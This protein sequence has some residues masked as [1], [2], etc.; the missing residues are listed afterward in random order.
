M[1]DLEAFNRGAERKGTSCIKW[2]FQ[3]ADYGMENL[4]PFSIADADYPTY[5]PILE[6]LKRRIDNGVIGYTDLGEDYFSAV[7]GWCRRRHGWE[8]EHSWVV[9][10]GGI[11]P[12]MCNAIEALLPPDGKVIVQPPVYDPFYSIIEASGR[13][14]VKNDLICDENGYRMDYDG[15]EKACKDGA[16]MLLLCSP[17]NP[18]CRVWTEEELKQVADICGRYGVYVVSDE[19]HWD[20]IMDGYHHTT[21]GQFHELYERL[22]VCTSCSKTFNIAGLETSNL[23]IPGKETRETYQK[24]LYSRYLFCPNTLGLEAVKAAYADGDQWVDSQ[25]AYLTGNAKLVCDFMAEH[26][27]R[28]RVARPEGTYLL[29]LDMTDYG[30]SSDELIRRIAQAGAG[31]NGGNHYGEAYDGFVRMN[32][33]CPRAQLTAGLACIKKAL[34]AL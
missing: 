11:V 21:M 8:I 27:P 32:V 25:R 23:I 6:A 3:K 15:L 5:P 1:S 33:A 20:L 4:L 29:W 19:I 18:V 12:A 34:E 9:P 22:I 16:S 17:H 31:L 14:M 30:L 10:T 26:L 7:A 2:D 13:K 24:W 28:V